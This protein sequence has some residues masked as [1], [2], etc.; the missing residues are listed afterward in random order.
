MSWSSGAARLWVG[1]ELAVFMYA[2]GACNVYNVSHA[3]NVSYVY[4]SN[5]RARHVLG[6]RPYEVSSFQLAQQ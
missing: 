2:P 3:C 5:A 6:C 4:A 1:V